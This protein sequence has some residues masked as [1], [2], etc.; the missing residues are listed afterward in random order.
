MEKEQ[1][2]GLYY[3]ITNA[4]TGKHCAVKEITNVIDIENIAG[5]GISLNGGGSFITIGYMEASKLI[6]MNEFRDLPEIGND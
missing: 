5:Y 2:L 1:L 4:E 6:E 3:P